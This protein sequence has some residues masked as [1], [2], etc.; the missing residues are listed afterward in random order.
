MALARL[1]GIS[2]DTDDPKGL[3]AFYR[4]LLDAQV[5]LESDDFVALKADGIYLTAM[6]VGD[7]RP[8]DWPSSLVPKQLHLELSVD[9]LD[10]AELEAIRLG[11]SRP[12]SQ[13]C[14]EE[15]RVLIDPAGHPFCLTT[16]IPSD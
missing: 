5:V 12:A 15:F 4:A 10:A 14:P 6:R 7:H 8:P 13:L 16:Q 3:A 9:D 1:G 2:L 11:A